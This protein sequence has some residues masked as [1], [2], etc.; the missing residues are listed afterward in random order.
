M[1]QKLFFS[2]QKDTPAEVGMSFIEEALKDALTKAGADL[3]I[4]E[5]LRNANLKIDRDTKGVAGQP[6][7]VDTIFGKID[8]AAIFL[9]DL[10][11]VGTRVDGRPTPNPNVCIE[12]GWALKSLSYRLMISVMN[13][14]YGEPD[15]K[16]LP[17]DIRHMRWPIAY[18]L[19]ADAD[20]ATRTAV[21]KELA[22]D[23]KK[24]VAAIIE[25]DAYIERTGGSE[26][27]VTSWRP[28]SDMG[29]P[30]FRSA[31]E[32]VGLREFYPGQVNSDRKVYLN[33]DAAVW[34][35]MRPKEKLD[36]ELSIAT[37]QSALSA[38]LNCI[39]NYRA[40]VGNMSTAVG[41]DGAGL[42]YS[43]SVGGPA[44][45]LTYVFKSGEIWGLDTVSLNNHPGVIPGWVEG[46]MRETFSR[47]VVLL[48]SLGIK[49]PYEWKAGFDG[50]RGHRIHVPHGDVN[51]RA[52]SPAVGDCL[53][54]S[55]SD[56]GIYLKGQSVAETLNPLFNRLYE[57]LV[58]N[59]PNNL[60][61][62]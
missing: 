22:K 12:H 33:K 17:F 24:A 5:A 29:V 16:S 9:S 19:L 51:A 18:N 1:Q 35:R 25:S 27:P 62:A 8:G 48:E 32:P 2:W 3:E 60:N 40:L 15:E 38:N 23:L 50:I 57:A 49:S 34:L 43:S 42:F 45:M 10:T 55:I 4:E 6:P 39:M 20:K 37:I 53:E 54:E 61:A 47:Y 14:A 41:S 58:I 31:N 21:R 59:R 36:T 28:S 44:G 11:F 46:G 52:F 30:Y 56:G 26:A 13:T 7:I